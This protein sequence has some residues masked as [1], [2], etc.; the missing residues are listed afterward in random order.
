MQNKILFVLSLL[1]FSISLEVRAQYSEK[2]L[3]SNRC[4]IGS[5]GFMLF[6]LSSNERPDFYQIN[7]GYRLSEKDVIALE[8]KT[9][10]YFEPLG[11]PYGKSKT[12]PT[13]NFPGSIREKGFALSYQRFL[14][15]GLYTAIHSMSAW[16]SFL[17][18][19]G[20]KFDDGFQVFNTYRL[21]YHIKLFK[22]KFF[23]EPGLAVTHRP[24]HTTMPED[25]RQMDDKWSKVFFGEPGFHI[26][27]NF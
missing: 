7:L 19:E 8:L 12:D 2:E 10:R 22:G 4:F 14:W 20:Q 1:L 15:K 6:N 5:T 11:I 27:F 23:I 26:G 18:Q 3:E 21:G 9:W 25:F 16:Q 17:N 24:Y 13:E